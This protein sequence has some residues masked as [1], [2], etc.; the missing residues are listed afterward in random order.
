MTSSG[1]SAVSGL[2]AG[3]LDGRVPPE[4]LIPAVA[5]E[6]YR[7]GDRKTREAL[8][9]VMEIIERASPG[10]GQLI[11]TEGGAGFDIRL[12]ERPFPAADEA[13]LRKAV[14][15]ALAAWGG[16]VGTP[17][18]IAEATTATPGAPGLFSRLVRAVRRLFS[19]SA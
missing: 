14:S 8:R 2:L 7:T 4:R 1:S 11:R 19:A 5:V 9:P 18:A 10:V 12:A 15:T 17:E 3:Y 13:E 16:G 6:Y